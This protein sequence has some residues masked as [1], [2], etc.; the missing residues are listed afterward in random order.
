MIIIIIIDNRWAH[1]KIRL[2]YD[3][4][5]GDIEATRAKIFGL[6]GWYEW[7][8]HVPALFMGLVSWF[9]VEATRS[10]INFRYCFGADS[11]RTQLAL[12]RPLEG[13]GRD[14]VVSTPLRLSCSWLLLEDETITRLTK[15]EFGLYWTVLFLEL[16]GVVA[17]V[18]YVCLLKLSACW[19]E[20]KY[21]TWEIMAYYCEF[22]WK[23]FHD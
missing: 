11:M 1:N 5:R 16:G 21:I 7:K 20:I 18:C 13:V 10:W 8:N 22:C 17:I 14:G 15:R 6:I 4:T 2:W 9:D 3:Q 12:P 19:E 23:Q